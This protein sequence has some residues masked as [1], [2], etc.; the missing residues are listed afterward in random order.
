MLFSKP[1]QKKIQ[2]IRA[3]PYFIKVLILNTQSLKGAV[4]SRTT[5][6]D[7]MQAS[8]WRHSQIYG[9]RQEGREGGRDEERKEEKKE[10][11]RG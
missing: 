9:G 11:K 7:L 8:N 1:Q 5:L 2:I 4:K 3:S 10:K 6:G